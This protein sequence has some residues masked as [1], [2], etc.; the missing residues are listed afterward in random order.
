MDDINTEV[1]WRQLE[2]VRLR[3]GLV[4]LKRASRHSKN[5]VIYE[6]GNWH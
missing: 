3:M 1:L 2:A 6:P 5:V 4:T